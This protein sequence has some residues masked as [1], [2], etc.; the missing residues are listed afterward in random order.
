MRIPKQKKN[1]QDNGQTK[2]YK[3]TYNNLQIITHKTKDR[4]TRTPTKTGDELDQLQ[5]H[6]VSF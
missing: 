1:R 6:G 3:I 2:K 4:V 5:K